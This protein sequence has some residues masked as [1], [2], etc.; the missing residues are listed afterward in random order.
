MNACFDLFMKERLK[1]LEQFEAK[2]YTVL[3]NK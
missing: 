3:S 1:A 2:V